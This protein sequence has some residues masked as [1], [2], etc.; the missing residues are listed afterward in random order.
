[1]QKYFVLTAAIIFAL[2]TTAGDANAQRRGAAA[3]AES[4][5]LVTKDGVSL[6]A[7]FYAGQTSKETTPV[8]MLHDFN[9]S[10]AVYDSLA[11]RLSNPGEQDSHQ[12][13]AVLTVDLRGHGDS[14]KQSYGGSATRTLEASRLRKGDV[15]AMVLRDME[16]VRKFLVKEN[17]AGKFN[18][19]R[20]SVI[21]TGLGAVVAANWAAVDWSVPPLATVKQ[22]Q[23][24][25]TMILVSP[26]WKTNG[27]S[28]N[29][30]LK[31]RGVRQK[32]AT[33]LLYGGKDTRVSRD[34]KRIY[35]QLA[36]YHDDLKASPGGELPSLVEFG[37]E[38]ELQGT[39]WLKQAGTKAEDLMIRFLTQYSVKPDFEYLERRN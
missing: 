34:N 4:V 21:G 10:R 27:L 3:T 35:K 39:A 5:T 38:T 33:M 31:Q 6:G 24:L 9:E 16:A 13:F 36:R 8:V 7:T 26:R 25:K 1:M 14:V 22:G 20:L 19:N 29:N 12:P 18:L 32:V 23:D 28:I 11:T 15:E 30:A 2:F 17:D 37:P